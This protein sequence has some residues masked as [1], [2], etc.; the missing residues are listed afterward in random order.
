MANSI[1]DCSRWFL[2]GVEGFE[3]ASLHNYFIILPSN[4]F[5]FV[6]FIRYLFMSLSHSRLSSR[7]LIF[8]LFLSLQTQQGGGKS[9]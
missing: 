2:I 7:A 6:S 3:R 8:F 4:S 1:S 5:N 9:L